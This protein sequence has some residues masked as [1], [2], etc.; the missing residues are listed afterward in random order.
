MSTRLPSLDGL[1]AFEAAARLASFERAADELHLTASAISK[2]V[3]VLEELVGAPL[4]VRGARALQLTEAGRD[5]LGPVSHVLGLLLAMPQHR[6]DVPRRE[7]LRV[8]V[9]PTFARQ[10][11]VPRLEGFTAARP[12]IELE[13]VLSLPQL[14]LAATDADVEVRF[15]RALTGAPLLRDTVLPLVTPA[16]RAAHG[17]LA[18]PA[19]LAGVPLLRSP[20]DPWT[21]WFRA[22]GLP[23]P[24]PTTG[25]RLAD[26]GL[27]LEAALAGQGV[28]LARPSLARTWLASGALVAPWALRA[29]PA[30]QYYLLPYAHSGADDSPAAVFVDWL[31]G[32]CADATREAQAL[33]SGVA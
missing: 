7:R 15:G 33:L 31:R 29:E 21:P 32:I 5:Y 14:D 24:E 1:R 3:A 22:A 13:L 16:L 28:A 6:R 19:A 18:E 17:G 25:P 30:H 11:L 4:F 12:G 23:W 2:R 27:V 20:L 26:L 8:C 9:P 10:V